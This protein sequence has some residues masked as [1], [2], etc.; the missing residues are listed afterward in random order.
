MAIVNKSA[1]YRNLARQVMKTHADLKWIR[2]ARVR[3]GYC[4]SDHDKK[5][6]DK[7]VFAD[8]R[9]VPDIYRAFIPYDFIIC[10]YEPN[11]M[12]LDDKQKEILMYHELLHV[13]LEPSGKLYV[14][15]HDVEEFDAIIDKHGLHWAAWAGDQDGT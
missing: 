13:G 2:Q 1:E 12:L 9:K 7:L 14:V 4:V 8:C 11:A 15:P 3:I 5:Q 10:V 6:V